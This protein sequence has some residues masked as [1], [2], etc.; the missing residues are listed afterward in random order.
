MNTLTIDVKLNNSVIKTINLDTDVLLKDINKQQR[1][2]SEQDDISRVKAISMTDWISIKSFIEENDI[3][4][5]GIESS[6]LG[7]YINND[8]ISPK[9]ARVLMILLSKIQ[10]MGFTP[11]HSF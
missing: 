8:K 2:E 7:Y 4:I 11:T 6:V 3:E 5:V 10:N 1:T 9:Q